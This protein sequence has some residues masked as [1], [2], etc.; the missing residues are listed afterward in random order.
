MVRS[1]RPRKALPGACWVCRLYDQYVPGAALMRMESR[2]PDPCART[3]MAV[4]KDGPYSP[5]V[6]TGSEVSRVSR[7]A[8]RSRMSSCVSGGSIR[9]WMRFASWASGVGMNL[10]GLFGCLSGG[11][12][13]WILLRASRVFSAAMAWGFGLGAS[14]YARAKATFR[15]N[16]ALELFS[17]WKCMRRGSRVVVLGVGVVELLL[18]LMNMVWDSIVFFFPVVVVVEGV[19]NKK[20]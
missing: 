3:E 20:I 7:S 16:A 18:L 8:S 11:S 9:S 2:T 19:C 1:W 12:S 13:G 4:V 5:M 6:K 10:G 15:R 17:D 14:G